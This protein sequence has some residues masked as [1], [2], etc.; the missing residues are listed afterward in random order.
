MMTSKQ[1]KINS[2]N[3]LVGH[4]FEEEA[5]KRQTLRYLPSNLSLK[6]AAERQVG[7]LP[8]RSRRRGPGLGEG[9]FSQR[10]SLANG[11][12]SKTHKTEGNPL[13]LQLD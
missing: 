4:N 5:S 1:K 9:P 6:E 8:S 7:G 10:N 2:D 3:A 11:F 13:I 12:E